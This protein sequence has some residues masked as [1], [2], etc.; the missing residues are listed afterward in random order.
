M[1]EQG[2]YA[3]A[4][5]HT[6][7]YKLSERFKTREA[8]EAFC[9]EQNEEIISEEFG[10]DKYAWGNDANSVEWLVFTPE[11]LVNELEYDL[12]DFHCTGSAFSEDAEAEWQKKLA[13]KGLV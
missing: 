1:N 12:E 6:E 4:Y 8:A 11:E 5:A 3:I 13:Q 2:F 10:G 7:M 9:Q